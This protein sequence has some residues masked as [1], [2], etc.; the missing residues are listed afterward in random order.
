MSPVF[1][2]G[3]LRLYLLKLLD[4][5]PSHGYEVI[6]LLQDRFLGVYAPSPGTI[7]PRLARLEEDG[8]VTHDE[9]DGKKVYRITEK[10]REEIRARLDD[11]ADLEEE[12]AESVRDIAREVTEDV[13]ETVRSLREELTWVAR[14][15]RREGRAAS[16]AKERDE[17]PPRQAHGDAEPGPSRGHAPSQQAHDK[18]QRAQ[19]HQRAHEEDQRARAEDQRARAEDLRAQAEE[20]RAQAEEQR[21]RADDLW[22]QAEDQQAQDEDQQAQ[23]EDQQA[24]DEDQRAQDEGRRI[25]DEARRAREEMRD[26]FRSQ[27]GGGSRERAGWQDWAGWAAWQERPGGGPGGGGPGGAD[28]RRAGERG[29][30]GGW[31]WPGREGGRPAA[32]SAIWSA[33][34]SISPGSCGQPQVTRRMS[35]KAGSETCATSWR[36]PSPESRTRSS[37]VR[38]ARRMPG[39]PTRPNR[40]KRPVRPVPPIRPTPPERLTSLVTLQS[41]DDLP[42][43]LA[44]D[45][46]G[47]AVPRLIERQG[48]VDPR[49]DARLL[50]DSQQA[51][52]LVPAA[53]GR[54]DH[55]QLKEEDAS[56]VGRRRGPAGGS[57]D[58]NRPAGPQG[59]QRVGP[60]GL[61]DRLHHRVHAL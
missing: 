41:E 46:R 6:R 1:R 57:A 2:H 28:R 27:R 29:R 30:P 21:A 22:A 52:Q 16:R 36:M 50:T 3:R 38:R 56:Q 32:C 60:G 20:L 59:A 58:D 12:L 47:E 4:E 15:V 24:Q 31:P 5:A 34:P 49:P 23:D 18:A 42:E 11:L 8:L 54:S 48:A 53:H 44:G 9:V 43:G 37:A 26:R 13:R 19:E 25:R 33:W 10:G 45:H 40:P 35:A 55:R 39:E 7:Y 51:A 17:A 61:A 14:D